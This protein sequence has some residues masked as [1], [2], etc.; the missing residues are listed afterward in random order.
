M[1]SVNY[2]DIKWGY[3]GIN[4]NEPMNPIYSYFDAKWP[5]DYSKWYIDTLLFYDWSTAYNGTAPIDFAGL[6][7]PGQMVSWEDLGMTSDYVEEYGLP[8][9]TQVANQPYVYT[10]S[11]GTI[12]IDSTFWI[13]GQQVSANSTV[14]KEDENK[15]V[16]QI[17]VQERFSMFPDNIVDALYKGV[18]GSKYVKESTFGYYTLPCDTE[19]SLSIVIDGTKYAVFTEALV[20]KNP[21]G[22]Q[23]IGSV[24]TKGEAVSAVP[25]FDIILGFQFCKCSRIRVPLFSA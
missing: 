7:I 3:I 18:S 22:D 11:D 25:Q 10:R 24:F 16:V 6:M 20:A 9:L 1:P 8:D 21:W 23:C 5:N 2:D 12:S 14:S 13:S 17:E 15:L 4:M 19:I